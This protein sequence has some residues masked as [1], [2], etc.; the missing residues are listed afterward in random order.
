M[1]RLITGLSL[2]AVLIGIMIMDYYFVYGSLSIFSEGQRQ[3]PIFSEI[4]IWILLAISIM[5]LYSCY[6]K[7]GY[8]LFKAPL[9]LLSVS[10]Y[11]VFF[12][13]EFLT[14]QGYYA[15]L[16]CLAASAV[17]ELI[18]FTFSDKEKYTSKDLFAEFS[19]II[20]PTL[21]VS[22]AFV[23]GAKYSG[24]YVTMFAIF[25][26][27]AGDTFA[28][29]FGSLLHNKFPKQ[30]C[31]TISPKKT[32]IG[33]VGGVIGSIFAAMVFW[34]FFEVGGISSTANMS[35]IVAGCHY[36]LFFP[37]T[38]LSDLWRSG[39]VYAAIGILGAFV[40]ELG[41]LAASRIKRAC[42]IKDFGSLFP[43]H[44]G[45]TDREDSIMFALVLLAIV[46]PIVYL[47]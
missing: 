37:A 11:P 17:L 9:I 5:E 30:M 16:I 24:I 33:A 28:Y 40:S 42:G 13:L 26:A 3:I 20:Y 6:S 25:L 32:V 29:W 10:I 7:S 44:G 34:A 21:L 18:M 4:F 38:Q 14:G 8:N 39:L 2:I 47:A 19:I 41:D 36:Q 43:G 27:V 12:V 1:K 15:I 46:L 35:T 45:V 23:L 22:L 31:P